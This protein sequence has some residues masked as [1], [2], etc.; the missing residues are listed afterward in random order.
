MLTGDAQL[1]APVP[2]Q[3][4]GRGVAQ[5]ALCQP[6]AINRVNQVGSLHVGGGACMTDSSKRADSDSVE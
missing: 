1:L 2:E 6:E 4:D 3:L 5:P